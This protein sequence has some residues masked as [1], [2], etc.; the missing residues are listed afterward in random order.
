M[1]EQNEELESGLDVHPGSHSNAGSPFG[2]KN[3]KQFRN[4]LTWGNKPANFAENEQERDQQVNLK[5]QLNNTS[6]AGIGKTPNTKK[7][8]ANRSHNLSVGYN[9]SGEASPAKSSALS[10]QMKMNQHNTIQMKQKLTKMEEREIRETLNM[11]LQ[12]SEN[13]Q[14]MK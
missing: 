2:Q 5:I 7:S 14:S 4:N 10:S 11:K 1:D 8:A 6:E 3:S 13:E 9:S 12:R